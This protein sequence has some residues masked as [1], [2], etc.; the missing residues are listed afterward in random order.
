[1][2]IGRW[3]IGLM[4]ALAGCGGGGTSSD[5]AVTPGPASARPIVGVK[6]TPVATF[7]NPFAMTF[8]PNGT[9]LVSENTKPGA[10]R[11]VTVAGR[12]SAPLA[13]L[14]AN[15]GVLD[16]A[17]GP[18]SASGSGTLVHFSFIEPATDGQRAGRN[19]ADLSVPSLGLA[20]GM[21]RLSFDAA[22]TASLSDVRV[23]WHQTPKIVA[24]PGSGEFGGRIT[25]SPDG[26]YLFLT[27]G[28]RQEFE[29][30]QRLDNTLGKIVRLFPDG[31]IPPDNPFAGRAGALLDIWTL[32]HRN[33]YGLV[34]DAAGRLWSHEMGP[35]GGDE[36]NLIARGGNYG[37][38]LVSQ[39]DNY[40]GGAIPRHSTDNGFVAPVTWWTPV[41]AP[42]G[43]MFCS[44]DRFAA[45][46]GNLLLTG[47]QSQGL[48]RVALDASGT[49]TE[50]ERISFDARIR[51]VEQGP[52]GS[53]WVL[54]DGTNA[55]LIRLAPVF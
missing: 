4:L 13:G 18:Q 45:W 41:I 32:G 44:G 49:A 40:D 17:V 26:R 29:P 38:P 3:G 19:A 30:V 23:I 7:D 10:L 1:M 28:D 39:G 43:M 12:K 22:G 24:Y 21:A 9:I 47:L 42:A 55:R 16:V 25:F 2:T 53:L 48:V 46:R 35:K 15:A 54:E 52:D 51:E 34:F 14:P 6:R 8:L 37:W 36:L 11:V 5:I 31:S 20:L 33:Q 27:A 50:V